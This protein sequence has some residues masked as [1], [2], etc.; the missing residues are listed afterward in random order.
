MIKD[1][2]LPKEKLSR[3]ELNILLELGLVE[4]KDGEIVI[5]EWG[6]KFL[7]LPTE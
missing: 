1:K 6:D 2:R 4:I 3:K 7:N 5:T